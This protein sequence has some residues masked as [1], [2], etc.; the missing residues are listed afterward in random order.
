MGLEEYSVGLWTE[1][2][3]GLA[4][5]ETECDVAENSERDDVHEER[6]NLYSKYKIL[7]NK[8]L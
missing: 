6:N 5:F 4:K 7:L 2:S 8:N 3:I 1:P